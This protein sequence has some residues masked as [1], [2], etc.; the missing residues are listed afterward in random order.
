MYS[1]EQRRAAIELCS[2]YDGRAAAAV[3]VLGYPSVKQL[4]RWHRHYLQTGQIPEA[5]PRR[6]RYTDDQKAA[7]VRHYFDTGQ[8]LAH[9]RR[10]LGYP[11]LDLLRSWIDAAAGR[12]TGPE[13]TTGRAVPFSH[14][15][16]QQAVIQLGSRDG[17]AAAVAERIGVTRCTLYNWRDQL[18]DEKAKRT[19]KKSRHRPASGEAD[20]LRVEVKALEKRVH[21]LQLEHDILVKTSE[22]LKKSHGVNPQTLT[23]REKTRLVDALQETYRL[24]EL[25]TVVELPRSS[26][27]Y[28]REALRR[29]DKYAQTRQAMARIF[30]NNYRCYGYRRIGQ[31]LRQDGTPLSEKVVRRLMTEEGL[32]VGSTQRRRFST[33]RGEISP[34]PENLIARDFRATAPNEKWLT[35][36]TEFPVS[37]GKVYL[38]PMIDCFD[39]L[40]VSWSISASPNAEL[41]NAMLDE[42]ISTL[43][44]GER[45]VVHS[46]SKTVRC[47]IF[48]G[49]A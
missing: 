48:P 31:S 24:Q 9:T 46:D 14:T 36:I 39:G 43:A 13:P 37:D 15:E 6:S 42:A 19:L 2:H 45:P 28:H 30:E 21:E 35:D 26:Y 34:A 23:N 18:L 22:I 12:K 47:R 20:A 4:R 40:V 8:C 10:S 11:N 29:P 1:Y 16:K 32:V 49:S 17:S 7:A 33:Y 38:S 3:R 25:L 27:Y 41:V 5:E 44:P